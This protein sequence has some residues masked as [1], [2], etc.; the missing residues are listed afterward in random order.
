[1]L[2]RIHELEPNS[3]YC[4]V[5]RLEQPLSVQIK[6]TVV[7]VIFD[8]NKFVGGDENTQLPS[9]HVAELSKFSAVTSVQP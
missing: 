5:T 6:S 2:S 9:S 7:F 3:L 8:A 4:M 1:M